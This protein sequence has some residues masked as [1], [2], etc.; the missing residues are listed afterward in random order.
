[1]AT[2][3]IRKKTGKTWLHIDS[4]LGEFILSQFY[5]SADDGT[6]QIVEMGQSKRR[7]YTVANI[8]LYDDTAFGAPETFSNITDLSIRLEELHYPAFGDFLTGTL[9]QTDTPAVYQADDTPYVNV[10]LPS[11]VVAN[12][13][14]KLFYF[15]SL[16]ND[17]YYYNSVWIKVNHINQFISQTGFDLT[18]TDL[19]IYAD[20]IWEMFGQQYTNPTDVII[21]IPLCDIGFTRI[22]YIVPNT[23]NGFDRI[24]GEEVL[25]NP[26]APIIPNGGLYLTFV[27]VTDSLVGEPVDPIIGN[28]FV[29][30]IEYSEYTTSETGSLTLPLD[31]KKGAFRLFDSGVTDVDSFQ[32]TPLF[33]SS[34]NYD[35]KELK[36][37]NNT[38]VDIN[39]IHNGVNGDIPM[40]F[41]NEVDFILKD[42]EVAVFKL[43][44]TD[45]T[46]AEFISVSRAE[47]IDVNTLTEN[48]SGALSG[49]AITDN[50]DGTVNIATGIALLRSTNSEVGDIGSY[51]IPLVTN[52]ALTDNSTNYVLVDYNGGSQTITVTIDPTTINT[53]TNSLLYVIARVGIVLSYVYAGGQNVD[54]NG[55]LRRRFLNT[56]AFTRANGA[57]ISNLNR[58]LTLT[59]GLFYTGLTPMLTPSFDTSASD[60]FTLVYNNG[61][62]WTR[63]TGQTE[64]NNT[65]YNV[66]GTLTTMANNKFRVD[67]IYVLINNPSKLYVVL[68]S[69]EYANILDA[70]LSVIPAVLPVELQR[71]GVLVGR[72]IIEKSN[73]TINEIASNFDVKFAS[74]AVTNHNDLAGLNLADYQHLTAAEKAIAL[75]GGTVTI[76]KRQHWVSNGGTAFMQRFGTRINLQE[77]AVGTAI[78]NDQSSYVNRVRCTR[79]SAT[80]AGS[81]AELYTGDGN[82]VFNYSYSYGFNLVMDINWSGASGMAVAAG[83]KVGTAAFGN[84]EP[85]TK[86]NCFMLAADSTDTNLQIMHNDSS[87]TC[88]KVDLGVGFPATF[89]ED[90]SYRLTLESTPNSRVVDWNVKRYTKQTINS[91]DIF[92]VFDKETSGTASTNINN[93]AGVSDGASW[94]VWAGNRA[95][96][97][98]VRAS[99]SQVILD[100]TW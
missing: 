70:R 1:M 2:I 14:R 3:Q 36:I 20:W 61:S 79:E 31:T 60:P 68:G 57:N 21:N 47:I 87:G 4:D 92:D 41:P 16:N 94:T 72:S 65:Q 10:T 86:L 85:S 69:V 7:K 80:P 11:W 43:A 74:G 78:A 38:G 71:L 19:T 6:F 29:E 24:A 58:N 37:A 18:G 52:L 67:Y 25:A 26:V 17:L 89:T 23:S 40:R 9:A 13:P 99:V 53:T 81:L 35:N 77:S 75:A 100:T 8:T 34:I 90:Y 5:F 66:S 91:V 44:K 82:G 64:I 76:P 93:L 97:T 46:N 22:D 59:A 62:T 83:Q 30:K 33:L 84:V 27:V 39:L 48:S 56:E 63:T 95:L 32:T 96:T 55:K 45:I 98:A 73:T 49:F 15:D 88:T 51:T 54:A 12:L 42:K 50:G 28:Q